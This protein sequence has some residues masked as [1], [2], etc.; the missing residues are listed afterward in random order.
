M[1]FEECLYIEDLHATTVKV[2]IVVHNNNSELLKFD[3]NLIN[4]ACQKSLN[5]LQSN[6]IDH[7]YSHD[8]EWQIDGKNCVKTINQIDLLKLLK[9]ETKILLEDDK[10]EIYGDVNK[11]KY[12]NVLYNL[13]SLSPDYEILC[14]WILNGSHD[15]HMVRICLIDIQKNYDFFYKVAKIGFPDNQKA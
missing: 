3:N 4:L 6:P 5:Y 7:G 13:M 2:I 11:C 14:E 9:E 8:S 15:Y 10:L 1:K 12:S